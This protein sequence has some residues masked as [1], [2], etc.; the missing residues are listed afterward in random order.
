MYFK[1]AARQT[2]SAAAVSSKLL[3]REFINFCKDLHLFSDERS[4]NLNLNTIT[5]GK[6]CST[7]QLNLKAY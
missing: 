6:D 1:V 2:I 4:A 3:E 5:Q 7:L